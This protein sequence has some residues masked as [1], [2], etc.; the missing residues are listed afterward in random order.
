[1]M[2]F[3]NLFFPQFSTYTILSSANIS[4]QTHMCVFKKKASND[5]LIKMDRRKIHREKEEEN[6]ECDG[7]R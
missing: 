7:E 4:S 1:M 2:H 5:L 6:A 3:L